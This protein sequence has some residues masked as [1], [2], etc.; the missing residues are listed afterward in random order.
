MIYGQPEGEGSGIGFFNIISMNLVYELASGDLA[1]VKIRNIFIILVIPLFFIFSCRSDEKIADKEIMEEFPILKG[2]VWVYQGKVKWTSP[3]DKVHEKDMIWTMEVLETVQRG[4]VSAAFV[5]GHPSDLAWYDE[6]L[7]PGEYLIL[8][9]GSSKYYMLGQQRA[10]DTL[11]RLRDMDDFLGNLVTDQDMILELPMKKG[12]VFGESCQITRPDMFYFWFVESVDRV[13]LDSVKGIDC[14][15]GCSEEYKRYTLTFQ[16]APDHQIVQFIPG[17]GI[18][19]YSYLH[20]GTV[21]EAHLKLT[22][23]RPPVINKR[24]SK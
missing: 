9:V 11:K 13:S 17:V 1:I 12:D 22:E 19:S 21:S 2:T 6:D 4:H 23:Y 20:H 3:P 14:A 24:D 5:K 16:S 8:K 7:E 18:S 15:K 10:E